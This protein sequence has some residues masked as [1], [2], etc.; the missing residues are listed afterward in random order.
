MKTEKQNSQ[1]TARSYTFVDDGHEYRV[2]V[3]GDRVVIEHLWG[4]DAMGELQWRRVDID[5]DD[6]N[7]VDRDSTDWITMAVLAVVRGTG[8]TTP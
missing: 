5:T 1:E 8:E 3:K 6:R 7:E 2:V 4:R